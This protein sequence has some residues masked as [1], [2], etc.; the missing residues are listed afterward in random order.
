MRG[1]LYRTFPFSLC[2]LLILFRVTLQSME[3]LQIKKDPYLYLIMGQ[4]LTIIANYDICHIEPIL[5]NVILIT[6]LFVN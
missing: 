1:Q 3:Y 2:S 6:Q 5:S 4:C